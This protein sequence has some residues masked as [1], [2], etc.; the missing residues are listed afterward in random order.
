MKITLTERELLHAA[1]EGAMRQIRA[2]H[3]GSQH[4]NP[5][6]KREDDWR[7]SIESA[8]AEVAASRALDACWRAV[9]KIGARDL[10]AQLAEYEVR[11]STEADYGLLVRQ[12]DAETAWY[13]LVIGERGVY[14]VVGVIHGTEAKQDQFQHPGREGWLP[15]WIV[16]QDALTSVEDHLAL[17]GPTR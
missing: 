5:D 14:D 6:T 1:L 15:C 10:T 13:V 12:K 3:D 17:I 2:W 7:R 9:M 11:S 16:P 4:L 8:C